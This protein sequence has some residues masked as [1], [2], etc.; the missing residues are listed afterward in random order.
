MRAVNVLGILT[1]EGEVVPQD[2][3]KAWKLFM[4]SYQNGDRKSS[5]LSGLDVPGRTVPYQAAAEGRILLVH[6]RCA[7]WGHHQPVCMDIDHCFDDTGKDSSFVFEQ[8]ARETHIDARKRHL[9]Q[10]KRLFPVKYLIYTWNLPSQ[11]NFTLN[12]PHPK[13]FSPTQ[14]AGHRFVLPGPS[15]PGSGRRSGC[16][17]HQLKKVEVWP[18]ARWITCW[19]GAGLWITTGG[20]WGSRRTGTAVCLSPPGGQS[21]RRLTRLRFPTSPMTALAPGW[22]FSFPVSN[23]SGR[24]HIPRRCTA[25]HPPCGYSDG[26]HGPTGFP[27]CRRSGR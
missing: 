9:E 17:R 13:K 4:R 10:P 26:T 6:C 19:F 27:C 12:I 3:G 5:P 1:L 23:T 2:F 24:T 20:Q 21:S 11:T 16:R 7:G 15:P 25:S 14:A 8:L 22:I 18:S